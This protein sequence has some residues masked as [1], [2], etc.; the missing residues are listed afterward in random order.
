MFSYRHAFHAGNHAD[1]L[2]HTV[3]IAALQYLLQ[4]PAALTVVDTHAGAGLYHLKGPWAQKSAEAEGGIHRLVQARQAGVALSG[5]LQNYLHHALGGH[6]RGDYRGS[7]LIAQDLLRPQDRLW[8]FEAH[9]KDQGILR[10]HLC[11]ARAQVLG[12]DGFCGLKR[13]L[14]PPQ[15]R[16]LVLCDPSYEQKSDYAQVATMLADALRRFATGTYMVWYPIIARQQAH[17]LPQKLK[18]LATRARR[19][20]LHATL[21]VKAA[22]A[23]GLCAS[24]VLLLNPPFVLQAQLDACLPQLV[25][26]LAQDTGARFLLESG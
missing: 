14:P 23:Q 1:V 19:P 26:C 2:K 3:W 5:P 9:P 20:W 24:G 13:Y 11:S 15:R 6:A 22:S 17:A 18:N 8:A 12:E 10:K 7:P 21:R 4:K 25:Q 16:A